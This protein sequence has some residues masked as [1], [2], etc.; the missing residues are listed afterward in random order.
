MT[1]EIKNI[2]SF[3]DQ[4]SSRRKPKKTSEEIK[5]QNLHKLTVEISA[6]K[7]ANYH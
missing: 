5:T 6:N 7:E 1:G 2:H 3:S 4:N